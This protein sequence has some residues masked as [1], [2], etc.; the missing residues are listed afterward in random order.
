MANT[1]FKK[2]LILVVLTLVFSLQSFG[3]KKGKSKEF[4]KEFPKFI[5]E[6]NEFMTASDNTD[7]KLVFKLFSKNAE[8]FTEAEQA[9]IIAISNKMLEKKLRAK[10]YFSEFLSSLMIVNNHA[11]GESM[12]PEWLAVAEQ[13][14]ENTTAK[15][16][17][18][19][20]RLQMV[21]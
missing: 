6:L 13:T 21:W 3:Q 20:V 10:P 17:C 12:L 19:F 4:P 2:S 11:K 7:L 9:S 15:K 8:T 1:A 18:Y 5:I 16:C 14:I